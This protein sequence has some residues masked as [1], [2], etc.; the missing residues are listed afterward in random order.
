MLDLQGLR[1]TI[2][3]G[4]KV[5]YGKAE[6]ILACGGEVTVISPTFI[7]AFDK[8]KEGLTLIEAYYDESYIKES[9]L[10]FAATDDK[11]CNDKIANDCKRYG[12]ACN[13][14]T[15]ETLS[16]F[17]VPSRVQRGALT[18]AISTEGNSPAL[19]HKIKG[20][21]AKIYDESYGPYV[22]KL[23]KLRAQI[24]ETVAHEAE[25]KKLL[26][27]LLEMEKDELMKYEIKHH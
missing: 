19:A 9:H 21:L 16:R 1:I 27:S 18:L 17:I 23:G 13:S 25:R 2:I 8:K 10:V 7:E 12:K 6:G 11:A 24:K 5:A 4:G 3:G 22:E 15:N 14:A 26:R 20:E